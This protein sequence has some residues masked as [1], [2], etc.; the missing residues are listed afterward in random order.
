MPRRH[1]KIRRHEATENYVTNEEEYF[2]LGRGVKGKLTRNPLD[3]VKTSTTSQKRLNSATLRFLSATPPQASSTHSST[4]INKN[5]I[6]VR[7]HRGR[8]TMPTA[9]TAAVGGRLVETLPVQK[10]KVNTSNHGKTDTTSVAIPGKIQTANIGCSTNSTHQNASH[11][12][13]IQPRRFRRK[14]RKKRQRQIRHE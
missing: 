5:V 13:E 3:P 6:T 8:T 4:E 1:R 9:A 2:R 11:Q 12:T 7:L 14:R 10:A